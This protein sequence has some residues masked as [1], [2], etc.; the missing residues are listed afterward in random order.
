MTDYQ[1]EQSLHGNL[2]QSDRAIVKPGQLLKSGSPFPSV[3]KL[4]PDIQDELDMLNNI[5]HLGWKDAVLYYLFGESMP[6]EERKR[7]ITLL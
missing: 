1:A 2:H 7:A 6:E 3:D 4:S 5:Q